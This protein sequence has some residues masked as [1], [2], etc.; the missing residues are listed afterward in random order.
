M[1]MVK[2]TNMAHLR[3][4]STLLADEVTEQVDTRFEAL[5]RFK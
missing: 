5:A 3:Y 1:P 4:E 2:A